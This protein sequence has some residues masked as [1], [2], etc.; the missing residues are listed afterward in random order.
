MATTTRSIKIILTKLIITVLHD[1]FVIIHIFENEYIIEHIFCFVI[2]F[3][4]M[5]TKSVYSTE[6]SSLAKLWLNN[7]GCIFI[8]LAAIHQP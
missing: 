4:I 6:Q 7:N 1:K 5:Q 2:Q 8:I 3:K